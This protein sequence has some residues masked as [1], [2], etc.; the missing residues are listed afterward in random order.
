MRLH[1]FFLYRS[2]NTAT[3][4]MSLN[5]EEAANGLNPNATRFNA[6]NIASKEVVEDMLGY[7]GIKKYVQLS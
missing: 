7:C 6:Y 2:S 5:Y 1:V 4:E 3:A